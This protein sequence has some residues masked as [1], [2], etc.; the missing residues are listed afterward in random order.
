ML[1]VSSSLA[2]GSSSSSCSRALLHQSTIRT[3]FFGTW[4]HPPL[5]PSRSPKYSGAHIHPDYVEG[6]PQPSHRRLKAPRK[7]PNRRNRIHTG[8][9]TLAAKSDGTMHWT[10]PYPPRPNRC[11]EPWPKLHKQN[12]YS[13]G[14]PEF[15]PLRY[16]N[17]EYLAKW[18]LQRKP[19]GK[20]PYA[21]HV[22]ARVDR[23][24]LRKK[25]ERGSGGDLGASNLMNPVAA[26][27][28][29]EE[30]RAATAEEKA[31]KLK[32]GRK[33]KSDFIDGFHV[34]RGLAFITTR[35]YNI[36]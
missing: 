34:V 23:D 4:N 19:H 9:W 13:K 2:T 18:Q 28:A 14:N 32:R 12:I 5:P 35:L 3:R 10:P 1:L 29:Y 24:A 33:A 27:R 6:H 21:M 15:F 16:K 17:I 7:L 36:H 22:V 30:Q 26:K 11:A 25:V 8:D 31:Q 20:T